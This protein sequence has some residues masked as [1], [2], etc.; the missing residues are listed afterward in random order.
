[1]DVGR[2]RNTTELYAVG[3][4]PAQIYPLRL[5]ISMDGMEFDDQEQIINEA[6]ER[7]PFVKMY[8]DRNGLGMNLAENLARAH[9]GTVEDVDFTN[10]SKT[11]WATD[12]KLLIQQNKTPLPA[13]KDL[14][15][16]IH[17]IK[18]KVSA[19]RNLVFDTDT[20]EK[21]HADKFWA[22]ALALAGTQGDRLEMAGSNIMRAWA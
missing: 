10:A 8:I 7:L 16:Q 22:W 11:K 13:D 21:H 1:M 9:A 3:W 17:S 2:T 5:S 18:R 20:A 4:G 19:G 6:L 12:A 15:Y 14:A